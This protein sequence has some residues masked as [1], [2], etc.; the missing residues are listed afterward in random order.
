MLKPIFIA[1]SAVLVAC[2]ASPVWAAKTVDI[3][4]LYNSNT[5]TTRNGSDINARIASYIAYAN[6]AYASSKVDMQ[7]RLVAAQKL[8]L[9][10]ANVSEANLN[11]LRQHATVAQLRR[12]YGADVVTYL[13]LSQTVSGGSICG[14]GY[15]P[16][17]N[18][19][20]GTFY[21]DSASLAFNLVGVDCNLNVF[22]HEVGHNMGL[23]H[24]YMQ[25]SPGGVYT[26]GRGHGVMGLFSTV[27]A[28]PQSYGTFNQLPIFSNPSLNSCAGTSCGVARSRSDGADAA[29]SLNAL[30]S[31]ITEFVPTVVPL[32]STS[33]SSSSSSSSSG[34]LIS[35]SSS[36]T[37]SSTSS[38]SSGQNF[39]QC[40]RTLPVNTLIKNGEFSNADG[41]VSGLGAS[42]LAL[43]SAANGSCLDNVLAVKNRKSYLGDA[44]YS[45]QAPLV[46]G[47]KY[48]ITA[49]ASVRNSA[50]DN[51]RVAVV[52][53]SSSGKQL[54]ELPSVSLT[55]NE[56]TQYK[57]E[58]TA[59]ASGFNGVLFFGPQAN[60]DL[61]LDGVT[62]TPVV[63]ATA[64]VNT[65]LINE[66]F[67]AASNGWSAV[68]GG[69]ASI[70][71]SSPAEGKFC[72]QI[73]GRT[74]IN[75]GAAVQ[76]GAQLQG[77]KSY[78]LNAKLRVGSAS[79]KSAST[80]LWLMFNDTRGAQKVNLGSVAMPTGV[81]AGLTAGFNV[82]SVGAITSAQIVVSGP[83][84]GQDIFVDA[85]KLSVV[86]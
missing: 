53:N 86:K 31:Q 39:A 34:K 13:T 56:F 51:M 75:S 78:S 79:G 27:M 41:W 74:S 9:A 30:A 19:T 1:L 49:R 7:L 83:A 60:V 37:S 68:F 22:T 36:S 20:S 21:P 14:I 54:F 57:A 62:L 77:G 43:S 67:E 3:L 4:V 29:G 61:L 85:V 17:G 40:V 66:G 10:I 58:F 15:I 69:K 28:Y 55:P 72:L 12:Q 11:A 38:S 81:W 84:V 59:P 42:T 70:V 71:S 18:S 24:S 73:S 8:D 82:Y 52:I 80:Q 76:L 6:Q 32:A 33:S 16:N 5:L 50:R 25:N 35:S 63:A 45:L 44:F 65:T 26:W 64:P 2:V 46:A 48:L 47:S 23:G